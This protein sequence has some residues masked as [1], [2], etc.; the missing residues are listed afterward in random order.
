[1]K[2]WVDDLRV[3]PNDSWMWC[4]S[5]QETINA[6]FFY[7]HN[8]SDDTITISLDHDAGYYAVY[9]GDYIRV[10]DYLE[11]KGIVDTGYF[12]HLHT[13][14]PVGRDNMRRIIKK[15]NWKEIKYVG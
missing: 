2:I 10:L 11:E 6:I 5:V 7:E 15:N 4:R 3:P 13:M 1:M 14:N 8:I 12:F 9:G